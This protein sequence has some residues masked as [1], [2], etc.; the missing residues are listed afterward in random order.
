MGRAASSPVRVTESIEER[1]S[2]PLLCRPCF[3]QLVGRKGYLRYP[4]LFLRQRK[5]TSFLSQD[6]LFALQ[7]GVEILFFPSPVAPW[8]NFY[9]HFSPFFFPVEIEARDIYFFAD[10]S[11]RRRKSFG[12]VGFFLLS[13]KR[14]GDVVTL[15]DQ[16]PPY[17]AIEVQP[18]FYSSR[19]LPFSLHCGT[20]LRRRLRP[21]DKR[22]R[23]REKLSPS[24]CVILVISPLFTLLGG[25]AGRFYSIGCF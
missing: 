23:S 14:S 24:L 20:R 6:F 4:S 15:G 1:S 7:R 16:F 5:T 25:R 13:R 11:S 9:L 3:L 12:G 22:K 21:S 10:M 2:L 18:F 8:K 17:K 19:V